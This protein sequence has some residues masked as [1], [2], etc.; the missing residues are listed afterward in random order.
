MLYIYSMRIIGEYRKRLY[1]AS[2]LINCTQRAQAF[3]DRLRI[4][5]NEN[6]KLKKVISPKSVSIFLRVFQ[7]TYKKR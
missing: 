3:F 6:P 4:E 7:I 1:R 2:L 5:L